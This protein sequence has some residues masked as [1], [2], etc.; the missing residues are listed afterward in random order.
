MGSEYTTVLNIYLYPKVLDMT[1]YVSVCS[2]CF[3]F[4]HCNPVCLKHGYLLQ[5]PHGTRSFSLKELEAV[6]LKR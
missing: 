5:R 3:T 4:P 6:F 2:F 1:L